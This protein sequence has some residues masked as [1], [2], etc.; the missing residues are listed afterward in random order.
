[1]LLRF[2]VE[3]H[4]SINE[5]QEISFVP[6]KLKDTTDGLIKSSLS[7]VP[8]VLPS[9][10]MYGANASGKSNFISALEAMKNCV[11]YSHRLND[12][13]EGISRSAFALDPDA[14]NRLTTF[15][16]DFIVFGVRYHYGFSLSDRAFE[17]EWLYSYPE[18]KKRKLFE[19]TSP[20]EVSFGSSLSGTKKLIAEIMR[21]NSLY[22]S[23]A[24][25]NNHVQL[26]RIA[27]YFQSMEFINQTN[28]RGRDIDR[29]YA[30]SG[31]SENAIDFLS[32]IGTGVVGY[33]SSHQDTDLADLIE[34]DQSGEIE[35]KTIRK[36]FQNSV[37][38][39][40]DA[41][42]ELAHENA[43]GEKVY[44]SSDRESA[45]TRRLLVL[46]NS[47]FTAFKRGKLVI[48]DEIDASLHT[49]AC[50]ALIAMFDN[51]QINSN[52]AQLIATTH[53]TNLMKSKLMRRDQIWFTEKDDSGATHLYPLSD[54][55][56][57]QGDNFERG[58]L[59]G[60][61]GA[62]PFAGDPAD[63]FQLTE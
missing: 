59:Q 5:R 39:H 35:L 52:N 61:F 44:L 60:R 54:I 28:V 26:T 56:T 11:V 38:N 42:I 25:Q 4:L 18:G 50:E 15:D 24:R 21:P 47:A 45:G 43:N 6:T 49:Q 30:I 13:S 17:K 51:P 3:N 22:V 40:A 27:R 63:F 55:R 16:M 20:D 31:I 53:D 58:Y 46:L 9:V 37:D 8:K 2:G 14:L 1:M 36:Y 19:R 34:T 41:R 32:K 23:A 48:I 12:P 62:I 33:R 29:N 7:S 57:R 10:L